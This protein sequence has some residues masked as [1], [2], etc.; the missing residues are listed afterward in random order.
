MGRT[1]PIRVAL[2]GANRHDSKMV[3]PMIDGLN[4]KA[5]EHFVG[6]KA[7]DTNAIRFFLK[8]EG[9]SAEI[10]GKR[11]RKIQPK[12]DKT[13]Y[14]WRHHIENMFAKLK[15]NRRLAMRVDKLD[16]TFMGFIALALIKL[17]VC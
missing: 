13:L 9:I 10:P 15:E 4:K 11:N 1:Q 12:F 16:V 3:Y 2:S 7:Y 5:I 17:M 8:S 14:K 6:D